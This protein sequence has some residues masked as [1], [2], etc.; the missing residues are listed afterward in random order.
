MDCKIAMTTRPSVDKPGIGLPTELGRAT[1]LRGAICEET[2]R[3]CA[4]QHGDLLR[5]IV[6]T[7]SLARDEA[8]FV[9]EKEGR[10]LLGD[11]EFFLIFDER[12]ALPPASDLDTLGR[13]IKDNLLRRGMRCHVTLSAV[14]PAYLRKLQPHIFAYELKVSGQVVWG[15]SQVLSLIPQFLPP[16]IPLEDAWRLLCNRMIEQLELADELAGG[17]KALSP[18]LHYRI[19]KLFLDM[20][21]SFLLFVGAYAPTYR[22]RAE[23]LKLLA[24]SGPDDA[25]PFSVRDFA[26]R[27]AACTQF[28]LT[29][30]GQSSV[31]ATLGEDGAGLVFWEEAIAYA[32]L[33]WR[34]EL[35]RLT[36]TKGQVSSRELCARW[37]RFQPLH[38][39]LRGWLYVL[40]KRGWHRSWSEWPRWARRSWRASPRY[41]VYAAAST[42]FFRLPCLLRPACQRPK[43]DANWEEV[44]GWLPMSKPG[45]GNDCP[46]WQ[47]LASEIVWNYHE[48]VMETRA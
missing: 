43:T 30:T 18:N 27:V 39:R 8:T 1:A 29:G 36:N 37:M 41:W 17:S 38:Y 20:A 48:F 33:L 31:S 42:L 32:R 10:T 40:R 47:Q 25:Y 5:A 11:A 15:E 7:G 16:D 26:E 46:S 34:W 22:E 24:D 6:L 23:K 14:H 28:K 21:T 13:G 35:A 9:E 3:L 44:R 4:Q 12:A 45:P 19:V 2:T